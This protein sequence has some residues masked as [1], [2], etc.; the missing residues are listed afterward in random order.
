MAR[1]KMHRKS[2]KVSGHKKHHTRRRRSMGA[3][4]GGLTD[5]LQLAG[6]I[7][8]GAIAGREVAVLIGK[9]IP[10]Q[11]A[12][13]LFTGLAQ[14]GAGVFIA[15]ESKSTLMK[16]IGY[17]MIANGGT[18]AAVSTGII[19]GV[20]GTMTYKLNGVNQMGNIKYI[21]GAT[22]RIGETGHSNLSFVAGP[23]AGKKRT[24]VG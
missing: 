18:T 10:S 5:L 3:I 19:S 16:G 7:T 13:P 9:V 8:L 15:K 24:V 12:N 17:G 20:P 4:S 2:R 21:A 6:G 11:Q 22:N 23:H 14:I 1:Y